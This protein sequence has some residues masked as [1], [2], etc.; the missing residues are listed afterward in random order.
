MEIEE[1]EERRREDKSYRGRG[2]GKRG[3][4]SKE[5]GF[6]GERG[7]RKREQH[8]VSLFII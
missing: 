2:E 4:P 8:N 1:K 6:P 3:R 7:R 5:L